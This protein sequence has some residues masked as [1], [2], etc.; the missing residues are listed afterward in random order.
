M[1]TGKAS[2]EASLDRYPQYRQGLSDLLPM[3]KSLHLAPKVSPSL[4]FRLRSRDRLLSRLPDRASLSVSLRKRIRTAFMRRYR[5]LTFRRSVLSWVLISSLVVALLGGGGVSVA[6]AADG[7]IPGQALYTL[8]QAVEATQMALTTSSEGRA[9]LALA[10]AHERALEAQTLAAQ[11]GSATAIAQAASGYRT[12]IQQ[13]AEA[14]AEVAASGDAARAQALSEEFSSS[15]AAHEATLSEVVTRVPQGAAPAI[16]AAIE[17]S[18]TGR[19]TVEGLYG[20]GIPGDPPEGAGRPDDPGRLEGAPGGSG[21][22]GEKGEAAVPASFEDRVAGLDEHIAQARMHAHDGDH[23]AARVALEQYQIEVDALAQELSNVATEEEA[24][25]E[26]WAALLEE[27]LRRHTEVLT[28]LSDQVPG[29]ARAHILKA[30]DSSAAGRATV[31]R[32][33][34]D[35]RPGGPPEDIPGRARGK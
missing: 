14:L 2:I 29:E 21:T 26:A 34:A 24:R 32:L 33:F 18:R 10:F 6:H 17:A 8:D 4:H 23:E 25:A 16:Q 22:G 13:A 9:E 30:L 7:S 3:A 20:E 28:Q 5:S 31:E 19:N 27:A 12:S 11:D 35:G 1:L 15:L